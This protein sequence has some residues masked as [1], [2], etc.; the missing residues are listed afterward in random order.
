MFLKA[1]F[2][3]LF[4]FCIITNLNL[5]NYFKSNYFDYMVL[6]WLFAD[7]INIVCAKAS[8]TT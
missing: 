6:N 3:I 2:K 1:N 5:T 8:G 7:I 4:L